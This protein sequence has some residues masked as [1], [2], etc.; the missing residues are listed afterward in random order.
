MSPPTTAAKQKCALAMQSRPPVTETERPKTSQCP[1]ALANS[2][3][4][5]QSAW[6]A[7]AL[8]RGQ[9]TPCS[10]LDTRQPKSKPRVPPSASRKPLD[11]SQMMHA[12]KMPAL[13]RTAPDI[14]TP[15]PSAMD[16]L[17]KPFTATP[18]RVGGTRNARP[19]PT[20]PC[21]WLGSS[22][23]NIPKAKAPMAISPWCGDVRNHAVHSASSDV[24]TDVQQPTGS[25]M[26]CFRGASATSLRRSLVV[27]AAMPTARVAAPSV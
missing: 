9:V 23:T 10:T 16:A 13:P 3:S 17:R 19:R 18:K 11:A 2:P 6:Q 4:A 20:K 21:K 15:S 24:N 5:M 1:E 22:N 8:S 27:A 7:A 14:E 25:Q 26:H 12:T